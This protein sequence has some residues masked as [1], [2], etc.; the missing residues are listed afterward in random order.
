MRTSQANQSP[1]EVTMWA[2]LAEEE[3][4]ERRHDGASVLYGCR[5]LAEL[6]SRLDLAN[7]FYYHCS[8]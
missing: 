8:P 5:D 2:Q 3:E 4:W 7:L 1:E 6:R